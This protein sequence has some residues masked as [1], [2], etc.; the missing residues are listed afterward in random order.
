LAALAVLACRVNGPLANLIVVP[1][2]AYGTFYIAFSDRLPLHDA[3]RYGDF[4]YGTYLYAFPIQQMLQA[5]VVLTF[6]SYIAASLAL[7]LLAGIASWHIVE[8]RFLRRKLE[9]PVPVSVGATQ[10]AS[11]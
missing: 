6:A 10:V 2:L 7:S 3:A 4:S 5:A 9:L 11:A 1:A 8:K